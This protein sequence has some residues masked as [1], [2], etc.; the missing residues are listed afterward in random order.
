M[1]C[2]ICGQ[3]INFMTAYTIKSKTRQYKCCEMCA[4]VF[5]EKS[6]PRAKAKEHIENHS[7]LISICANS[8]PEINT[9]FQNL[10]KTEEQ[11]KSE[12]EEKRKEREDSM[13]TKLL[14]WFYNPCDVSP[15]A[16]TYKDLR[17]QIEDDIDRWIKKGWSV[18]SFQSSSVVVGEISGRTKT[19]VFTRDV[20][21]KT[22]GT[23]QTFTNYECLMVRNKLRGVIEE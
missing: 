23:T 17:I 6:V 10:K 11:I 9:T 5:N 8:D 1:Q 12:K 19:G 3:E 18:V 13:N 14:M 2:E 22:T 21:G 15:E 4:K 7:D 16:Q 20:T